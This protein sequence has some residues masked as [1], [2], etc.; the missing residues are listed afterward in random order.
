[1]ALRDADRRPHHGGALPGLLGHEGGG[2]A[3]PARIQ[4][5]CQ[6]IARLMV[7]RVGGK[8]VLG[9]PGNPTSALVTARFAVAA[10]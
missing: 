3:H 10:S 2:A 4:R 5:Q 9:L 1:V 6:I 7:G 8:L